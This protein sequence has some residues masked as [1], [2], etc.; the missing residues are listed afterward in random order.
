MPTL[1]DPQSAV[2][3]G[4]CPA[5][6]SLAALA[7]STAAGTLFCLVYLAPSIPFFSA[8]FSF[9]TAQQSP[10]IEPQEVALSTL[11]QNLSL[12]NP[13]PPPTLNRFNFL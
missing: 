11:L 9:G 10:L 7:A 8:P 2:L 1:F 4:I 5:L 6:A 3:H 12:L 13:S